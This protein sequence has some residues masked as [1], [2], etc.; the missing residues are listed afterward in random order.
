MEQST[1]ILSLSLEIKAL[2]LCVSVCVCV[3]YLRSPYLIFTGLNY[4][5]L[6]GILK[7]NRSTPR[8]IE[9]K[10]YKEGREKKNQQDQYDRISIF[11]TSP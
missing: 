6:D 11:G 5:N 7:D 9:S 8:F 1:Y 3:T 4:A 2:H 10:S